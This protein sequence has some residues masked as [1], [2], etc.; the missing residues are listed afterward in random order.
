[1]VDAETYVRNGRI[2][3]TALVTTMVSS[4]VYAMWDGYIGFLTAVWSVPADI[5]D[6]GFS[7]V[8]IAGVSLFAQ[9][10]QT[11]GLAW[12]VATSS[13]PEMGPLTFVAAVILV[14]VVFRLLEEILDYIRGVWS[15]G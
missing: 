13:L 15:N 8:R 14:V 2:R 9:P 6:A 12:S 11:M 1:M 5:A 10:R 3:A 4:L 7:A